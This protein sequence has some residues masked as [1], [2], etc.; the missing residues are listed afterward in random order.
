MLTADCWVFTEVLEP[1]EARLGAREF[2]CE[3]RELGREL[4]LWTEPGM[5]ERVLGRPWDGRDPG[6][7]DRPEGAALLAGD[8][9]RRREVSRSQTGGRPVFSVAAVAAA[10]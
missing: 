10:L 4:E 5:G 1:R 7:L 6:G 2:S 3:V 8:G 9:R